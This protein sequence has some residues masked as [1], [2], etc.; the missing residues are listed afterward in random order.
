MRRIRGPEED[1]RRPIIVA[2]PRAATLDVAQEAIPAIADTPGDRR[3]GDAQFARAV[4]AA[5][6]I[7]PGIVALNAGH[8][9]AGELIVAASLHAPKRAIR[10]MLAE[11]LAVKRPA[12][13]LDDP[14]LLRRP[15]A[16]RVTADIAARPVPKRGGRRWRLIQRSAHVGAGRRTCQHH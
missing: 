1:G 10:L 12:G 13:R 4:V 5:L 9:A 2:L 8:K 16:A 11:R 15:R 6:G 3:L 14:V 7:D